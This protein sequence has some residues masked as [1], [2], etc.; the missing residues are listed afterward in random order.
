MLNTTNYS[1]NDRKITVAINTGKPH[2]NISI[3]CPCKEITDAVVRLQLTCYYV[4]TKQ[5]L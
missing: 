1:Q 2:V 4:Y 3:I 5:G